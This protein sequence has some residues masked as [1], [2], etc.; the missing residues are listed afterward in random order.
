MACYAAYILIYGIG[1]VI[2]VIRYSSSF[3]KLFKVVV[4]GEFKLEA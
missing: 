3:I 4:G 2:L 1:L